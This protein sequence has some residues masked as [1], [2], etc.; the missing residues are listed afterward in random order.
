MN[1]AGPQA[2][3]SYFSYRFY[4]IFVLGVSRAGFGLPGFLADYFAASFM[5]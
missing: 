5:F 3:F 1:E 4:R 2:L